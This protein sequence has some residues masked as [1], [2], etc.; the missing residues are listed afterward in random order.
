MKLPALATVY[1]DDQPV[2]L[3]GDPKPRVAKVVAAGGKRPGSV[4]VRRALT[5]DDAKG[6][7]VQMDDI[8]DRTAVPTE[9]IYLLSRPI[10]GAPPVVPPHAATPDVAEFPTPASGSPRPLGTPLTDDD[11]GLASSFRSGKAVRRASSGR[12]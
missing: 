8:I 5:P 10:P 4:Q 7:V 3:M 6:R 1:L 2:G 12:T 11:L 9:P